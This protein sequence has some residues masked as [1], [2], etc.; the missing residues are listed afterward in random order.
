M[1]P[2]GPKL[3]QAGLATQPQRDAFAQLARERRWGLVLLLVGWLHLVAFGA[4]YYLTIVAH[5][6]DLAGY[7]A[8]WLLELGG[9]WLLFRL[10]GGHRAQAIGTLE[11]FVRRVWIA[12]F[13]LA[14][15][16]GTLNTLRGHQ[17]FEFFPAIASLA[18]FAFIMTAI[19]VDRRFFAAMLVMFASGLLMAAFHPHAY[20]IFALAWWLVLNAIGVL[21][22]RPA[23]SLSTPLVVSRLT[24][25]APVGQASSLSK[26]NSRALEKSAPQSR[27]SD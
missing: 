16:L 18:S 13:V 15:N 26:T 9:V 12:Y 8:I 19:V 6:H 5:Y 17:H 22:L 7:L 2:V 11:R 23:P 24:S 25:T 21:L 10:C 14:F 3:L 1:F 27:G 4:C 20:L